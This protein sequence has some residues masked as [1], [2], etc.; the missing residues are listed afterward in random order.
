MIFSVQRYLEDYFERRGLTDVDQY[1]IHVANAFERLGPRIS[2]EATARQLRRIRTVFFRRN[3]LDRDDFEVQ[4]AATLRRK[5]QKKKNDISFKGF[6]QRIASARTRLGSRRRSIALLL[7]EFKR[8]VEAR[9]VDAFWE[10]RKK[11]RLRRKPEK[12][13]QA[14]LAIFAK[15]VVGR[16]GLVL[17]EIHSGIGFVD[18]G[19]SFG[20]V[21]HLVELK[22]LNG[23]LTGTNQLATYMLTEGRDRGWLVLIDVRRSTTRDAVPVKI[24]TPVGPIRT[25][26]VDVNPTAPHAM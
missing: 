17:R 7:S 23:R 18:V 6:E 19:V 4:L 11:H 25:L 2:E 13:A 26:V 3:N 9:A 22:I 12:I 8:A 15:G 1:A 10:S 20:G 24:H 21:L 16:D 14:L 5:F